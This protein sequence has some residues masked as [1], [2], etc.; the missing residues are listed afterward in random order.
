MSLPRV[1]RAGLVVIAA[2]ASLSA[3]G[4]PPTETSDYGEPAKLEPIEGEDIM[5]VEFSAEGARQV[6]LQTATVWEEDGERMFPSA[7]LLYDAEGGTFAYTS[8]ER[9]SYVREYVEVDRVD[10]G[11][12]VLSAGPPA[13]TEVVTVGAAE[14]YGT[15]FEVG[16]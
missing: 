16:N 12:V 2:G 8:P 14:V 10:G 6:G 7:A 1:L 11:N 4:A 15:E 9:L 5:R 13:G 3:C